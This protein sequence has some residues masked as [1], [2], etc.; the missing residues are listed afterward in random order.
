MYAR[1]YG[2]PASAVEL[3]ASQSFLR[4]ADRSLAMAVADAEQRR[5]QAWSI[6]CQTILAANEFAYVP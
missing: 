6:L 2:R 1:A 5:E 4:A 3:A